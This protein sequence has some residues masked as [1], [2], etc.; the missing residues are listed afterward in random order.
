MTTIRVEML[1]NGL[2]VII[3]E[4]LSPAQK[5]I[6][7]AV[8]TPSGRWAYPAF[9]P[10][11]QKVVED[12]GKV[13]P[14][15][16]I[17]EEVLDHVSKE[18]RVPLLM[19]REDTDGYEPVTPFYPHQKT[20][21][22]HALWNLRYGL[23]LGRGLGKTKIVVDLVRHLKNKD[24]SRRQLC[25]VIA[26]RVNIYTWK[27]EADIHSAGELRAEPLVASG[28]KQRAKKLKDILK[29]PPDILV[30]TYDTARVA[31]ELIY[32]QVPYTMIVADE[33][34]RLRGYK[35]QQT[36]AVHYLAKKASRR[37]LLTGTASLGDPR[38]LWGQLRFLGKFVVPSYWDFKS[39]Y[40]IPSRYHEHAVSGFK[41]MHLLSKQVETLALTL[42]AEDCLELPPRSFDHITIE[43]TPALRKVY[44]QI[45]DGKVVKIKDSAGENRTLNVEEKIVALSKLSQLSSGFLYLSKKN[46]TICDGCPRL[47]QCVAEGVKPYTK[48]CK[49]ET[50][51]PGNS[52][53]TFSGKN[54]VVDAVR[55]L[56]EGHLA[57]GRKVII[58][59]K[60]VAMLNALHELSQSVL[61]PLGLN[62]VRYDSTTPDL[63]AAE[64]S[65][66]EDSKTRVLVGQISMG[67]G[68]TFKAPAMIYAELDW[69]LDHWLQSL[70][71]N[72]GIRAK[73]FKQLLVQTIAIRGSVMDATRKLLT[74]KIDVA[75]MV[76]RTPECVSCDRSLECLAAG[77]KPYEPAC[78][79]SKS[80]SKA[81]VSTNKI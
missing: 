24:P 72:F 52:L 55:E 13:L 79:F 58:W 50:R 75:A 19:E 49:V 70:D 41:N 4:A 77:V 3:M 40:T 65:F 37:L 48:A 25:L 62:S 20:A 76:T 11:H 61:D 31:S 78:K 8:R 17:P 9:Y 18:D 29:D 68:V 45:V 42:E 27:E 26:L 43:P 47:N 36:K 10:Y 67:I 30:I 22:C 54:P 38:H 35:S 56:L 46:P 51:D 44:N 64:K 14:A 60:H 15:V 57:E 71:R 16:V 80:A 39:R 21:F 81:T 7:G 53:I 74:A 12:I 69:R 2:P 63:K 23:F 34:H 5:K 73:G 28:P 59:A 33:S 1:N 32:A 6:Y 66:N